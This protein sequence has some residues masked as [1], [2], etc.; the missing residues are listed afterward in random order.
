MSDPVAMTSESHQALKE[1]IERLETEGRR[2]IAD[3]IKTAREWGD[4]KEN[5]EYHDAKNA[6]AH[7]ETRIQ[8]LRD[9]LLRAEVSDDAPPPDKVALGSRVTVRDEGSGREDTFTLVP[10]TEAKPSEG[11]LSFEAPLARALNG[12]R[13]GQTVTVATPRGDRRMT[14]VSLG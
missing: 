1:E 3:R 11:K 5:A 7:L 14:V 10:A 9:K 2:E 4:L 12:A 8:N 13:P 6:Q